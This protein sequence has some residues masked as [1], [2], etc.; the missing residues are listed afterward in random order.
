MILVSKDDPNPVVTGGL[1]AICSQSPKLVNCYAGSGADERS[2]FIHGYNGGGSGGPRLS[3]PIV[4]QVELGQAGCDAQLDL[5]APYFTLSDT[6]TATI[7]AVIDFG[8]TGATDPGLTPNCVTVTASPGGQLSWAGNEVGGSR[9]TGAFNLAPGRTT[10]NLSWIST[11]RNTNCN[12]T[13]QSGS[14]TKV[15]APYMANLASGP[16]QYLKLTATYAAEARPDS[17]YLMPTPSTGARTTTT[18]SRS[19]FPV[20]SRCS[21]LPSHSS[22]DS[23]TLG[24]PEPGD[25]LRQ[26]HQLRGRDQN[27]CKTKYRVNYDDLDGDGDLEWR[28][29]LCNGYST[30][31]SRRRTSSTTQRRTAR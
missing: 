24:Q 25:R 27:G 7:S 15:A 31:T 19:G 3:N 26:E 11:P 2:D 13:T 5:S 10:L 9:F 14:F 30:A 17:P 18:R 22:F 28:N 20:L 8:V 12:Q 1:G 4:R 16:V 21:P 29:L 23:R 6:C